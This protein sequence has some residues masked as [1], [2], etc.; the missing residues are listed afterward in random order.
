VT[1]TANVAATVTDCEVSA[2]LTSLVL[3]TA[4]GR[5]IPVAAEQLR[6]ACKCA[7][8]QRARFDGRF[9][10]AFPGIAIVAVDDLGYGLNISFSDGHNRGIY[11][12]VYLL[13]LAGH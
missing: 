13:D 12:K 3:A 4:D 8:C 11:P 5:R 6:T 9:P 2:D 10:Q 7:H 1:M